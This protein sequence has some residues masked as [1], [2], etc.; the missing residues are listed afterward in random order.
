[1]SAILFSPLQPFIDALCDYTEKDGTG[2]VR[3][4]STTLFS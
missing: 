1:M 2:S 3:K 4:S